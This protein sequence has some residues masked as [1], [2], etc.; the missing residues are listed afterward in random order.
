MLCIKKTFEPNDVKE[1]V[2]NIKKTEGWKRLDDT[3][4]NGIR[5][6]FN[7]LP[8]EKIRES[9]IKEQ[10]GLCAYCMKRIK[11]DHTMVIEHYVPIEESKEG[12]LDY[13]NMLGCCDGG[14]C[15]KDEG[16]KHLCCDASKGKKKLTISPLDKN[17]VDGL[18]Y[19]LD[20]TIYYYPENSEIT[21]QLNEVLCLNGVRDKN[22]N[23]KYDTS[24]HLIG[25]RKAIYRAYK[26]EMKRIEKKKLSNEQRKNLVKK[27]I[28][29]IESQ[30]EYPELAGV[31]LYFLKRRLKQ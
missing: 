8:K 2:I 25:G 26:N 28:S 22:G 14:R 17:F 7:E 12:A 18:R 30:S 16:E 5:C 6:R 27:M 20:G 24:T 1:A 19:S 3:D 11:N 15:T 9:L 29:E 21:R 13:Y 31:M 10:H 23:L 4:T